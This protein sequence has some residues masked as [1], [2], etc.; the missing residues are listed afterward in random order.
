MVEYIMVDPRSRIELAFSWLYEEY[1]MIMGFCH[2]PSAI[3]EEQ[4]QTA[5]DN[6][7]HVFCALV[8]H[9]R[10]QTEFKEKDM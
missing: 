4:R 8:D 6:Y 1:S 10:K 3:T 2:Q 5:T 9:L 7:S